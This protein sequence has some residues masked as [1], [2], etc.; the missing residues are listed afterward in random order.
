MSQVLDDSVPNAGFHYVLQLNRGIVLLSRQLPPIP[1]QPVVLR[2]MYSKSTYMSAC[3]YSICTMVLS[4][5][6]IRH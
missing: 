4:R 6:I 1:T 5:S 2:T 3:M